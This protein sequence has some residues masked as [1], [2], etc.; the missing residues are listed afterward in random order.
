MAA[1]VD[2]LVVREGL[3]DRG[4][5]VVPNG[6]DADVDD[7]RTDSAL[8]GL[9]SGAWAT[10]SP[11]PYI[12]LWNGVAPDLNSFPQPKAWMCSVEALNHLTGVQ[13]IV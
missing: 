1:F 8:R 10:F 13:I 12:L 6:E 11:K 3:Q 9:W 2:L 4:E 7:W 5:L